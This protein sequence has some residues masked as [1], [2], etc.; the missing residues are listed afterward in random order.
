MRDRI[1]HAQRLVI[2][3]HGDQFSALPFIF[4]SVFLFFL[5]F[6]IRTLKNETPERQRNE[7]KREHGKIY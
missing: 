2:Y 6:P 1:I 7:T 5:T 4:L 3:A